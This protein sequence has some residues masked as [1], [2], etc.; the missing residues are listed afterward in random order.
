MKLGE[1]G[2]P[3]FLGDLD[4]NFI[5]S[6]VL[7]VWVFGAIIGLLVSRSYTSGAQPQIARDSCSAAATTQSS[8][9]AVPA[10]STAK[11]AR[12][13]CKVRSSAIVDATRHLFTGPCA[14]LP[15]RSHSEVRQDPGLS[16]LCTQAE[17]LTELVP[18]LVGGSE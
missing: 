6:A 2:L 14:A 11:V 4:V 15:W 12:P 13:N 10:D 9:D 3:T 5:L 7:P 8:R 17:H 1:V 18:T 16:W